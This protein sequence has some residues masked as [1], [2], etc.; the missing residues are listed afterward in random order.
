M[1]YI[2]VPLTVL[3]AAFLWACSQKSPENQAVVEKPTPAPS[4]APEAK[5]PAP[6]KTVTVAE[7]LRDPKAYAGKEVAV[8]GTFS[9]ICCE[10]DWFLKDGMDTIEVYGTKMCP[11]P[12]KKK[13][14]SKLTVIGTVMVRNDQPALTSRELRFE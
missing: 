5:A 1:R 12:S 3:A 11:I 6:A 4:A 10:S 8:K 7:L 14:Q 2:P 13:I 9:G